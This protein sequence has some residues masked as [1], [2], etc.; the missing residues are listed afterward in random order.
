MEVNYQLNI[1]ADELTELYPFRLELRNLH[2][3]PGARLELEFL[4][5]DDNSGRFDSEM[6]W[7]GNCFSIGNMVHFHNLYIDYFERIVLE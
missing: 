6:E 1:N 3:A 7:A 5:N 2:Q 4:E